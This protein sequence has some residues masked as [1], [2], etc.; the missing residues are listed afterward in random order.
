[1]L[2]VVCVLVSNLL[3]GHS[4]GQ[5]GVRHTGLWAALNVL[6]VMVLFVVLDFDRPRRGLIR[7]DHAPLAELRAA[8]PQQTVRDNFANFEGVALSIPTDALAPEI[9]FLQV[10]RKEYFRK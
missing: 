9:S 7:V 6:L 4:S 3:M 2:L 1:V 10:H 5:A 8:L